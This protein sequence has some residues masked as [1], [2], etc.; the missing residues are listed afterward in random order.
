M[1]T[2]HVARPRS[3]IDGATPSANSVA[4]DVLLRLALLTGQPDHDRRARSILRAAGLAL[5]RHP[6]QFGRM[7]AAADRALGEPIDAVIVGEE[8]GA[9]ALRRAAAAPYQPDL[10]IAQLSSHDDTAGWP[11][12]E[13]KTAR[14][15]IATAFVCRGY[16]CEEPTQDP[17]RVR[18][19]VAGLP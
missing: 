13:G 2:T 11:L 16:A 19:Q 12:F 18:V 14:D 15:D 5:E 8:P 9:L 6:V 7:L 3:L 17:D 4:A 1:S 10:V